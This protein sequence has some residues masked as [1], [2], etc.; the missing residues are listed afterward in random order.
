MN[1]FYSYKS[2]KYANE[3]CTAK[4]IYNWKRIKQAETYLK[5]YFL[6]RDNVIIMRK[7]GT[8]NTIIRYRMI[9]RRSE[10]PSKF[11][12]LYIYRSFHLHLHNRL[13]RRID[14]ITHEGCAVHQNTLMFT[15]MK[16][17]YSEAVRMET[18]FYFDVLHI[19]LN[20]QYY[21][22]TNP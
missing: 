8:E 17:P 13:H 3:K 15:N 10:I 5:K 12:I 20:S 22:L 6:D 19:L 11:I 14:T 7:G 9:G 2:K 4:S 1:F 18:F 21:E 16:Q